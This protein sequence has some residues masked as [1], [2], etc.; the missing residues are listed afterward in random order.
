MDT[1]GLMW[2]PLNGPNSKMAKVTTAP[3]VNETERWSAPA[4]TLPHPTP[5]IKAVPE[6][7]PQSAFIMVPC[8]SPRNERLLYGVP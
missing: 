8:E 5:T 6:N 7:S 2:A 3:N 1:A 4:A